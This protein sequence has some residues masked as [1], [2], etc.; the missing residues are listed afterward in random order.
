[1][2]DIWLRRK[3][4]KFHA[5]LHSHLRL[6]GR[7]SLRQSTSG[8]SPSGGQPL[9]Q[10]RSSPDLT[11][12]KRLPSFTIGHGV[13]MRLPWPIGGNSSFVARRTWAVTTRWIN[14]RALSPRQLLMGDSVLIVTGNVSF[15]NGG[16][17][18]PDGRPHWPLSLSLHLYLLRGPGPG[19][20]RHADRLLLRGP[21][22]V[23]IPALAAVQPARWSQLS[24]EAPDRRGSQMTFS[25]RNGS[26]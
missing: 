9:P 5:F 20:E 11:I 14:W 2:V 23:S 8:T 3:S 24:S 7:D 12:S 6:C 15:R 26:K 16:Q 10:K 4:R 13:S 19:L 22:S 18:Y 17:G 25:G 21:Y 1:M